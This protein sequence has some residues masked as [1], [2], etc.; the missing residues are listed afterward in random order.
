MAQKSPYELAPDE[1]AT[2][3]MVYTLSGMFWGDVI[4]K[5]KIRVG[6]W[7]KTDMAPAYIHLYRAQALLLADPNATRPTP[8]AELLIPI[9][10]VIIFHVMPAVKEPL[11]YD[12]NEP[13]R[14]MEPVTVLV[15]LYTL[16]GSLRLSGNSQVSQVLDV[17]RETFLSLFDVKVSHYRMP[18]PGVLEVPYA[19]VRQSMSLFGKPLRQ[20][21]PVAGPPAA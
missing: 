21:A 17:A 8:F 20:K 4:T 7:L 14:I 12:P 16:E 9:S 10:E 13:N 18:P 5:Q 15:D 6:A 1:T 2:Q 19:I 11:Y 3:V